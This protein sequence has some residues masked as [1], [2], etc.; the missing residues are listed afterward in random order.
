[1]HCRAVTVQVQ[2]GKTQE[3]I[4]IYNNSLVPAA[5]QQKGFQG[6]YLMTD[7]ATGK[8]LSITVWASE[9]DMVEGEKS[10]YY[11]EQIAKFGAVFAAAPGMEHYELTVEVSA[12][13]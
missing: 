9:T 10:G 3:A 6:A 5:K 1:M 4:D 8:A 2:P 11:Q 7:A 12:E 13:G